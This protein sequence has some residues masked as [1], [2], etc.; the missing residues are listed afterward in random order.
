MFTIFIK[1]DTATAARID[2]L[3]AIFEGAQQAE[4]DQLTSRMQTSNQRLKNVIQTTAQ[5]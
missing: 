3:I 1:F 2:K 4:V 5:S